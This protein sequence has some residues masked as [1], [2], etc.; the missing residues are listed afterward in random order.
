MSKT[1]EAGHCWCNAEDFP[2]EIFELVPP[3]SRKKH[4]IC[5][6]CLDKFKAEA[7]QK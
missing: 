7:A 3:E 1:A 6:K 2:K 4:C 5:K